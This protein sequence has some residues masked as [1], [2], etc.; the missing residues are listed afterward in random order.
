[1][2]STENQ[3]PKGEGERTERDHVVM[4]PATTFRHQIPVS[5]LK[6]FIT[7]TEDVYTIGHMG[8]AR[9]DVGAWRLRIEGMVERPLTFTYD[10]LRCL[11][12]RALTAFIECYGNPIEPDVPTRRVGNVVWRGVPLR[13]ILADVRVRPVAGHVW[14]EGADFGTFANVYSDRYIKDIPLPTALRE[15]VLLAYEMNGAPLPAEHGFPVRVFIPGY[16]GTNCVKWLTRIYL[17]PDRP[18]SLYTTRLYNR[19]VVVGGQVRLEPVREVDVHSV[20]VWPADHDVLTVAVHRI[21]GWAWSAY[22]IVQ[23]E[24]STDGGASWADARAEPR[25]GMHTWQPFVFEW[26]A[27]A[28]G[29]YEIH[30]RAWDERGRVQ[31]TLGRNRIHVITVTIA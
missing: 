29:E 27:S 18:E 14:L 3:T 9:V 12:T 15:D 2:A 19:R 26:D 1:M 5:R 23:V 31:P 30:C 21:M 7:P 10:E 16:F 20:I 28:P 17:A 22:E 6:S 13:D 4:D 11:P 8:I 24:V 25:G